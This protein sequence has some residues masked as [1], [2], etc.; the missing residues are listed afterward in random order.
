MLK[1]EVEQKSE[2]WFYERKGK[3]TG[4]M[5]KSIMGTPKARQ[6]AMYE[7]IAE[8]LTVGVDMDHENAMERG[9]R[10]E[11]DAIAMFEL[12]M[13]KKVERVGLYVKDEDSSIAN[14]PDG[15][16]LDTDDTES[17]EAKCMGGKN[18]IKLWLTNAVPEEYEWQVAQYFIVNPKL[19]ILWFVGFNPDITIHPLHI[20]KVTR[21]EILEKI[22]KGLI[23]QTVFL[24][25]AEALLSTLIT[26]E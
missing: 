11:P 23:G 26:L 7:Y 10:L 6:E 19:Q 5:L 14:S 3:I 21:G 16:V 8:R 17:V 24:Q 2:K 22:E 9:N 13:S 1:L 12:E 15:N 25:E 20:I 4:T 18:H